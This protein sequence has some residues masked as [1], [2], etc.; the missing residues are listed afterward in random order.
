MRTEDGEEIIEPGVYDLGDD[1]SLYVFLTG[2]QLQ[3]AADVQ[4]WA[5]MAHTAGLRCDLCQEVD[6]MLNA[7][8][9]NVIDGRMD[10]RQ[11]PDGEFQFR[12]TRAGNDA[13]RAMVKL[14]PDGKDL[15]DVE[16]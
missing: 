7:M 8:L 10:T 5:C 15:T 3:P 6:G 14:P 13:V 12:M 1:R 4:M 11:D 16:G 2:R 9:L